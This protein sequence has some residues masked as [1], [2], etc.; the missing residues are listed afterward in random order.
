MLE[1][2]LDEFSSEGMDDNYWILQVLMNL[3]KVLIWF[4]F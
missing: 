4:L 1:E 3:T 2:R